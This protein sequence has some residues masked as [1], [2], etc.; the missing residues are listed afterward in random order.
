[1]LSDW[2][3]AQ[4]AW[5]KP[6][7]LLNDSQWGQIGLVCVPEERRPLLFVL[8]VFLLICFSLRLRSALTL[9]LS[10]IYPSA[11]TSG[12]F[13]WYVLGL[14]EFSFPLKR[15]KTFPPEL[16]HLKQKPHLL[17]PLLVNPTSVLSSVLSIQQTILKFF[18]VLLS[19]LWAI[20]TTCIQ[21]ALEDYSWTSVKS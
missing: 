20:F 1:M 13:S 10:A 4:P 18:Q 17:A 21:F 3:A 7:Q 14:K 8:N 5:D 15:I 6:S 11:E 16:F 19:K 2:S 9:V 12:A